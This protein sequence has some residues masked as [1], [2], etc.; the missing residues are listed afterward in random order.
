MPTD[1]KKQYPLAAYNFMVNVGSATMSFTEVSGLEKTYDNVVYRHGLSPWFGEQ[2]TTFSFDAFVS[3]TMKRGLSDSSG[4]NP[5][6]LYDWLTSKELR[7]VEVFLCTFKKEPDGVTHW[8]PVLK[9]TLAYAVP[10]KLSAPTFNANTND[11]IVD[12]V[13]LRA[14]GVEFSHV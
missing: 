13:E 9:W 1:E 3:V 12:V 8:S 2:I 7:R 5:L 14:R 4:A 11:M 6:F 10:V